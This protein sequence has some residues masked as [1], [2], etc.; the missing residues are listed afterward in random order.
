MHLGHLVE[1]IQGDIY[2]RF[3]KL[4]GRDAIF[5]GATDSHGTPIEINAQNMTRISKTLK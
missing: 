3:L 1:Y 4:A 2:S 5:I